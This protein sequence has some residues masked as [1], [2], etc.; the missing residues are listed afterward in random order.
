MTSRRV[1]VTGATGY[2]G[3]R[4]VPKLLEAGFHVRVLVRTPSKL[5]D[6][7]WADQVEIY[8]GDLGDP[9]SLE[10][11]CTDVDVLYYLVHSMGTIGDF[12]STERVAAENVARAAAAANVSRIVYLGGLHPDTDELS[13]HLRSRMEVGRILLKSGVPTA[14]LQAGVV[15]GSGSTSFEMIRHLTDVLPYMPAPKWVRNQIQPIA[16]RDVLYYLQACADLPADVNRTF[17]I[18]GPDVLRYG[19]MMNGYALEA[20]LKQRAIAALP[21]LTPWL[22]SQWVN[23]VTPI[24][25][26]LAIPIIASLQYDCIVHE[27]DI[28]EYIPLPPGGLTG[29]R[30]AV[31][32][33]LGRMRDGDVETSWR[34]SSIEGAASNPLPS[35]PDWAG[36]V[37]YTDLREKSTP[38]APEDLWR[39]IESIGG[40]NGWYSFPLAWAIR[41]LM[42]KVVGG[43]GLRRGRRN[44]DHLHIGDVLDFW[45]VE[46]IDH[47]SFLRLRAE[48]RVPG[49]AWL[50]MTVTPAA[51]GGSLYR[52][53]AVFFPRGLGG[54]LYWAVVLPFHG[55]IFEGMATRITA[56]AAAEAHSDLAETGSRPAS[57]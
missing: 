37:V 17:D 30:R 38:A 24:P 51:D 42:D 56:T 34:N 23:L 36:H 9:A 28:D 57:S 20:G 19:Q 48:M 49:R 22:A 35:D 26:N 15:I 2:L 46:K 40:E 10:P 27:R 12:E 18:G 45:R 1:L 14:A 32:L 16:V 4:L 55:I 44:P 3:G 43:V 13:P 25:R 54:R 5:R 33:A 52:Q 53:R 21:V 47:G 7:P 39:V 11:A 6:V 31:R 29:Y 8:E 50:E 41:G